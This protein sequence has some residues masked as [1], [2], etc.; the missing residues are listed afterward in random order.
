MRI[1]LKELASFAKEEPHKVV[2]TIVLIRYETLEP[3]PKN[4]RA[5]GDLA[6]E[7]VAMSHAVL[8]QL[9][10]VSSDE[11]VLAHARTW[12]YMVS[13]GS[14]KWGPEI[15]DAQEIHIERARGWKPLNGVVHI[16][17]HPCDKWVAQALRAADKA[18]LRH[19]LF[20]VFESHLGRLV[21]LVCDERCRSRQLPLPF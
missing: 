14:T 12:T 7:K 16:N 17:P 6:P 4:K 3:F 15:K 18:A 10:T 19:K 5:S 1:T 20:P 9:I 2:G 21:T 11:Y 13:Y 8:G